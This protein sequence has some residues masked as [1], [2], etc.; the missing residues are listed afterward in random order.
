MTNRT[1]IAQLREMSTKEA[2]GLPTAQ[3]ALLLEDVAALKADT[4]RLDE[5]LN[6]ALH[7]RFATE[8]AE[9]RAH[10]GKMSGTV[11]LHD[12]GFAVRADLPAKVEWDQALLTKACDALEARGEVVSDLVRVKIEVP[13]AKYKAWPSSIRSLFEAA[14]TVSHG[15][16][17]YVVEVAKQE[18]A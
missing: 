14:R 10:L 8:A 13:E 15:R 5:L 7:A 17:S 16:P 2:A 3:L 11:T 4:K 18:A 9:R 6:A 12:D 1:T